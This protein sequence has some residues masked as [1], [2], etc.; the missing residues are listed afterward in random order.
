M[1][2]RGRKRR[3]RG[4]YEEEGVKGKRLERGRREKERG[5]KKGRE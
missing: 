4:R 2:R 3:E 1:E 5:G